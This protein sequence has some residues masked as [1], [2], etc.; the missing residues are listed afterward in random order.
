MLRGTN[1]ALDGLNSLASGS[2]GMFGPPEVHTEIQQHVRQRVIDRGGPP[3]FETEEAAARELLHAKCGYDH[4][5]TTVA[6]FKFTKV[7]LPTVGGSAPL[8]EDLLPGPDSDMVKR[9]RATMLRDAAD[10]AARL[11]HAP[12]VKPYHDRV[13]SSK[14]KVYLSFIRRLARLGLVRFTRRPKEQATLF[15]VDKKTAPYA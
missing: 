4:T 11:D 7:S 13:F 10:T 12:E 6:P 8:I 1:L 14:P 9:F 15:F 5:S 3:N 2:V